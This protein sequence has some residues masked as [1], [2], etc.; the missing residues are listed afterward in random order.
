[1]ESNKCS[2]LGLIETKSTLDNSE[3]LNNNIGRGWQLDQNATYGE[4]S[5]ISLMW[6]PIQ[7]IIHISIV[8]GQYIHY[9][10]FN[11]SQKLKV[12]FVYGSN[13][14]GERGML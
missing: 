14:I 5:R 4:R 6:N 7:V 12:T 1:M 11:K 2:L 9:T 3:G 13:D 8:Y 10:V